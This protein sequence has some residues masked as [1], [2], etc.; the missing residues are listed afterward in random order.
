VERRRWIELTTLTWHHFDMSSMQRNQRGTMPD[1]DDRPVRKNSARHAADFR[2]HLLV[3]RRCRFIKEQPIRLV[4]NSPRDR[5]TLLLAAR[6]ALGPVVRAVNF[7][8]KPRE[9]C[10]LE[11][12]CARTQE[13]K[14]VTCR[15]APPARGDFTSK[16]V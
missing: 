4:E 16:R 7:A 5:Q 12:G 6:K 1:G 3:K 8:G 13:I 14:T 11:G 9:T 10:E 2:F 15:S